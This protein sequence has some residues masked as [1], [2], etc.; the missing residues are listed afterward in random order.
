M[1][2]I[3][4]RTI[5]LVAACL[6]VTA[7]I[8]AA[9]Q[10]ADFYAG[11]TISLVIGSGEAGIYDLGGRVMARHLRR[12]IPGNPTI[13]PRNMPGASS[14]VA[15]EYLYNVA[16]KDG[17]V[18][19]TAQPTVVLNKSLDPAA[20]YQPEK[21]T[22]IGRVQ[23]VVLVGVVWNASGVTSVRDALERTVIVSA[24]GASGTSAIVPWALNR[25]A[26]TKFRV[27]RGY[28]SQRPQF[29]AME[30]GEVQGVG[31]ASLSDVL[32]NQDW[33]RNKKVGVLYTISQ[34][35]TKQ[36]PDAPA[37]VELARDDLGRQVLSVLGSVTDIGQTL[38]A[39][40]GLP[41]ARLDILRRAFEQMVRDPE[42]I[43]EAE[44]VG[45]A[46][47]PMPGDQLTSLVATA[48]EAPANVIEK[49]RDVTRPE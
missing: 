24:S 17:L 44:R 11:K 36:V 10:E 21:F 13:V 8:P 22:W 18:I 16:P 6:L 9:A 35:R 12:F 40:P 5:P 14:V 28:E 29:L 38:M 2:K 46:V 26:G 27:I 31:S 48:T 7:A 43:A 34:K 30:R 49:L 33:T 47:D 32:E 42:F 45:V 1:E 4:R 41:P 15:A 23:P 3:G 39:P 20:K 25:L 19:G 37:I